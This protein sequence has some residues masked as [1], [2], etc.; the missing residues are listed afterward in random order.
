MDNTH[1]S[2]NIS[3]LMFLYSKKLNNCLLVLFG[4]IDH[5]VHHI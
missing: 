2:M 3:K 4:Q 1:L 5:L